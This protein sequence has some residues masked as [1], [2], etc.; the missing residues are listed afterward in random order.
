MSEKKSLWEMTADDWKKH[1][2]ERRRVLG[3]KARIGD[4]LPI[5]PEVGEEHPPYYSSP[6]DHDWAHEDYRD[7]SQQDCGRVQPFQSRVQKVVARQGKVG[8]YVHWRCEKTPQGN[9]VVFTVVSKDI[10]TGFLVC[11]L[12]CIA[13]TPIDPAT[14][15]EVRVDA[16]LIVK[17]TS[18]RPS[19]WAFKKGLAWSLTV[20]T[21]TW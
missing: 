6:E 15:T 14:G 5:D 21:E 10:I 8:T 19:R 20:K 13:E 17:D 7:H 9:T 11:D 12:E 2:E 4:D 16:H 3:M 1:R 18:K